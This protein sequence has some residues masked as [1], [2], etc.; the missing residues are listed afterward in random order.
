MNK[1]FY[2]IE[3]IDG[4]GK[5]TVGKYIQKAANLKFIETPARD[6][7]RMNKSA[8]TDL[9]GR[10]SYFM[11]SNQDALKRINKLPSNAPSI[12]GRY[13]YSTLIYAAASFNIPMCKLECLAQS[14]MLAEPVKTFLL[15]IDTEHQ[16]QR[17]LGR[18]QKSVDDLKIINDPGYRTNID[19][20]YRD[21]AAKQG[22]IIVDTTQKSVEKTAKEIL[23]HMGVNV[24]AET[25]QD[26]SLY[27]KC[28]RA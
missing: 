16:I 14:Y 27:D 23:C 21:I 6:F 13:A 11:R 17:I 5:T 28:A 9:C 19:T 26:R 10:I 2:V 3:G 20:M 24:L 18:R 8:P 12:I 7:R 25:A 1:E 22:W 15:T 4:A